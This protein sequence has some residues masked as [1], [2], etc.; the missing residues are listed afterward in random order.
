MIGR[1]GEKKWIEGRI[2]GRIE[3]NKKEEED[4]IK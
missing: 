4:R 3:E 1:R 2:L